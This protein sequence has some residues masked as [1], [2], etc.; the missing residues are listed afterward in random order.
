[1]LVHYSRLIN[2][3]GRLFVLLMLVAGVLFVVHQAHIELA[4]RNNLEL[5]WRR[6]K[7]EAPRGRPKINQESIELALAMYGISVP[8]SA[9]RPVLS[10]TL[11]DRGLSLR[12]PWAN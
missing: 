6:Q 2:T 7:V 11:E 10:E 3:L 1:I 9:S 5:E 12:E 8:D 4:R